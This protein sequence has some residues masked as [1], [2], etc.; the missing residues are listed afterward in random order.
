MTDNLG[1][2]PLINRLAIAGDSWAAAKSTGK[3]DI[4]RAVVIVVN[5]QAESR[6][7]FSSFASPVP[8]MDTILGAT[9]IP[10]NEYTFESLM[11]V[12]S[13]MAGFKK[14]FVEGRCADRASKGEDTAGCDDF[15]DDL[16]IIDLDNIT[17]KEK[18]ERLKQL[19]TSFVLKP[20]EVDEL[21]KAAREIIGESKAFQRFI[22]DVN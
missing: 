4:K 21:R 15:E 12:K 19:P 2:R 5:A 20:E 16:I 8:L 10:L 22:N 6:T 11:A 3:Q 13:T 17:N 9:S 14:G 1:V 7:H 18:R